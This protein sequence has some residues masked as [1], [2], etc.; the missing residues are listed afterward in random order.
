MGAAAGTGTV[1]RVAREKRWKKSFVCG[2]GH[3]LDPMA[4]CV[5]EP[6]SC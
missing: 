6:P 3:G 4:L 2:S 5:S 1:E